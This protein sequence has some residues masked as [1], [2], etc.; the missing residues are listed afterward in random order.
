MKIRIKNW[1]A[2]LGLLLAVGLFLPCC[3]HAAKARAGIEHQACPAQNS[4]NNHQD[5][6]GCYCA[7]AQLNDIQQPAAYTANN[8]LA[9]PS[10]ILPAGQALS[11]VVPSAFVFVPMEL[12]P[13]SP[14]LPLYLLH[15]VFLQ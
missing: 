5:G 8:N 11:T 2:V 10:A 12:P 9:R 14:G 3:H 6:S 15:S 13:V 4:H 7:H 1:T